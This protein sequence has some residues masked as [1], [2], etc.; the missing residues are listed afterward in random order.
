MSWNFCS[1]NVQWHSLPVSHRKRC[2]WDWLSENHVQWHLQAV[3]DRKRCEG[4]AFHKMCNV[5]HILLVIWRDGTR[6]PFTKCAMSPTSCYSLEKMWW[7]CLP[8]NMQCHSHTVVIE[9]DVMR[10]TLAKLAISLTSCCD[11]RRCEVTSFHTMCDIIH[12]L[13]VKKMCHNTA[14]CKICNIT[15]ILLVIGKDEM[16]LPFTKC[17]TWMWL[18]SC[19]L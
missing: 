11:R 14:F 6:L 9:K 8:Q 1:Q 7:D 13:L 5:T 16:R 12:L 2:G 17:L 3:N 15:H 10:L 4:T 19:W 18:T